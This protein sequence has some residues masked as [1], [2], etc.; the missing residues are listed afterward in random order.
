MSQLLTIIEQTSFLLDC[1]KEAVVECQRVFGELLTVIQTR[2]AKGEAD[3]EDVQSL[4]KVYEL[5]GEHSKQVLE[6][7]QVDVDFLSEQLE[8]LLKLKSINDPEQVKEILALLIDDSI[9]IKD[10]ATF[11]REVL[12][13]AAASK[14]GLVAMV[15]DIK[16]AVVEGSAEEV[17]M[18]LT[19]IIENDEAESDDDEDEDGCCSDDKDGCGDDACGADEN[20][21]CACGKNDGAGCG[22]GCNGCGT[23]GKGCGSGDPV[24]ILGQL[25]DYKKSMLDHADEKTQH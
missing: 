15:N 18:Y 4:K 9:E 6:E 23:D 21:M 22:G 7:A 16:D 8:S 20:G 11:K 17:A 2:L 14:E 12:E 3:S 10:T 24:D 5:I 13:E 19:T 1:Q 25:K